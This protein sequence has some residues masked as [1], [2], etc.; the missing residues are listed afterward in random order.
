MLSIEYWILII[1]YWV[2]SIEYYLLRIE[3]YILSFE[4]W[5]LMWHKSPSGCLCTLATALASVATTTKL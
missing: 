4:Y 2:P 5:I 1:E 3:Y